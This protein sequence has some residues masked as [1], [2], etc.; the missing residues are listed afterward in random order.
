MECITLC[1]SSI[2]RYK[3]HEE[4]LFLEKESLRSQ[5]EAIQE[6]QSKL[7]K[8]G[9]MVYINYLLNMYEVTV[10]ALA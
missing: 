8:V 6:E 10:K 3:T 9:I 5:L 4:A 1:I 2:S 7:S